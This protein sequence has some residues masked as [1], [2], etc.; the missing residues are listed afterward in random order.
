[1]TFND[2]QIA[3]YH[4]D[5]YLIARGLFDAE[6]MKLLIDVARADREFDTAPERKDA[7]GMGSKIQLENFAKD[8]IYSVFV[9]CRRVVDNMELL[10]GGEVYHWHHK[11]MLKQ[12]RVG[13]AWEWHQDY[14]YWYLNN[15]CLWP[16]MASCAIAVDRA[17]RENGC[18]QLLKGSHKCGR[19]DHGTTGEQVG[20][21]PER[22]EALMERLELVYAE[23]EPGDALFFHG[24][25]LHRSDQNRSEH[26]RWTLIGCY[27]ATYNSPYKETEGHPP[28]HPL[29]KIE[30]ENVKPLARQYWEKAMAARA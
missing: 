6:E 27:N 16:D 1:M 13:G 15:L 12:P 17:N 23:L 9:C 2:K 26:S 28:Y 5:G 8:D 25:T 4:E 3:Q 29:K 24:N 11:M 18:M 7:A 20:A 10:M 22:V 19:I 30:D 21:D 14:G